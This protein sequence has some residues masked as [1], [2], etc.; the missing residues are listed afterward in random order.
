[1]IILDFNNFPIRDG[2]FVSVVTPGDGPMSVY[3]CQPGFVEAVGKYTVRVRLTNLSKS[4][5]FYPH[6]LIVARPRKRGEEVDSTE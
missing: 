1:M 3:D 5:I 2:D 4:V 6:E